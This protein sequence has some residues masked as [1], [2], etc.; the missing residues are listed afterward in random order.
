MIA[1]VDICVWESFGIKH[2]TPL[3][4]FSCF[5]NS[6]FLCLDELHLWGNNAARQLWNL[7]SSGDDGKNR[8]KNVLFLKNRYREQIGQ[9][10]NN[11]KK[12]AAGEAFEGVLMGK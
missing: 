10:M 1:V 6:S 12:N 5:K 3:K 4:F 8:T 7:I 11:A 9:V 2:A